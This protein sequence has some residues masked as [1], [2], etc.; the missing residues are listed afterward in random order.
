MN[1][2]DNFWTRNPRRSSKVSKDSD[3]SLV[4]NKN[5]SE[6]LPFN[7]W[8]PG[9]GEGGLK[10][11]HLWCHSQKNRTPQPTLN[12]VWLPYFW[13]LLAGN[14]ASYQWVCSNNLVRS[15]FEPNIFDS[16]MNSSKPQ[17][18]LF[19]NFVFVI[20]HKFSVGFCLEQMLFRWNE[21]ASWITTWLLWTHMWSSSL[22]ISS[23][24]YF[25]TF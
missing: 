24:A 10:V 23:L 25:S 19:R 14:L 7:S 9:P 2:D 16:S 3:C 13:S 1:L 20:Y 21:A 15:P 17:A 11:L 12:F 8:R 18:V 5:F 6:I 4:S 22:C